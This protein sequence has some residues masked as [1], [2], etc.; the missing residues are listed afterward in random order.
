MITQTNQSLP[1]CKYS[2]TGNIFLLFDNRKQLFPTH[3]SSFVEKLCNPASGPGADG[4][5]LLETASLPDADFTMRIF[6]SDCSEAEM[7]GNGIRCLAMFI[8]K[9][10]MSK[11]KYRI[12]TAERLLQIH[13][14]K[15]LVTVEMGQAS[16]IQWDLTIDALGREWT[17]HTINTGVLHTVL[18]LPDLDNIDIHALGKAIRFHPTFAPAGTNVDFAQLES[19]RSITIRTYERGVEAETFACGTGATASALVAAHLYQADSPVTINTRSG[20]T[21]FI[22][23]NQKGR[24]RWEKIAMTGPATLVEQGSIQF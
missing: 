20:G 13:Y 1:Y 16:D 9:L 12:Q 22:S 11:K 10:G 6:N 4:I 3:P 8:L 14:K 15:D 2:G 18:F 21:I 5:I 24:G 23:F 19:N 17:C 7:C